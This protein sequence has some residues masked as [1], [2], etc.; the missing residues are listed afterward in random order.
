MD[1][2]QRRPQLVGVGVGKAYPAGVG[3]DNGHLGDVVVLL[4]VVHEHRERHQVVDGAVEEALDLRCVKVD[5]HQPVRPCRLVQVGDEAGG[6]GLASGMLLVLAAV[7]IERGDDGDPLGGGPLQ[8]VDHDQLFHQPLVDRGRVAL[9]HEGVRAAHRLLEPH[10]DLGVGV[11][12]QPGRDQ[13][14]TEHGGDRFGQLREGAA[15]AQHQVL[16]IGA[17]DAT[18]WP[19]SFSL[20]SLAAS[21]ASADA[22]VF[23]PARFRATQPGML[24]CWPRATPSSPGPTSLVIV[25]PAAT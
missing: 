6:D 7:G 11:G 25:D 17:L 19:S 4:D 20:A 1:D 21:A 16:L 12:E 8:R 3:R 10:V 24:R 5:R 15:R 23:V 2:R 18:H 22:A 9:D 13:L 14:D